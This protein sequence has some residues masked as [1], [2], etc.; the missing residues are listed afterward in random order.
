MHCTSARWYARRLFSDAPCSMPSSAFFLPQVELLKIIDSPLCTQQGRRNRTFAQRYFPLRCTAAY[1]E[2]DVTPSVLAAQRFTL[3]GVAV[4]VQPPA[5]LCNHG[6]RLEQQQVVTLGGPRCGSQ[7]LCN[8]LAAHAC[9]CY[10]VAFLCPHG[11]Q[12]RRK[13]Q[14]QG[15]IM[16]FFALRSACASGPERISE[17]I[18]DAICPSSSSEIGSLP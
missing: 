16:L 6:H 9:D 12:S 1:A 3:D 8:G 15:Y 11:L 4:R 5:Q 10:G 2:N 18:A 7:N 13:P 17:P 14:R